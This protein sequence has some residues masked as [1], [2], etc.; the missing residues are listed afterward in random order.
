MLN[1]NATKT[2]GLTLIEMIVAVAMA[3]I[4]V[5]GVAVVL[6]NSQRAYQVTY[7]KVNSDVVTDAFVAR[8]LFDAVVRKS[9][10]DGVEL[11]GDRKSVE[12]HY[13]N[14]DSSTYLD[15]YA[16]FFTSGLDLKIEYGTIDSDGTKQ[17]TT[18]DTICTNVSNCLFMRQG[19]SIRMVLKFDDEQKKNVVVTSAYLNN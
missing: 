3:V 7:D 9:S 11:S 17:T 13:Y 10:T 4:V 6:V 14:D 12:V 15:R 16:R 8:R 2:K 1:R 5:L 19:N 18:V